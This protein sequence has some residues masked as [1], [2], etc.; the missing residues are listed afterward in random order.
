LLAT[1]RDRDNFMSSL[2]QH[3]LDLARVKQE[4]ERIVEAAKDWRVEIGPIT[5]TCER[6]L[7]NAI[8][9]ALAG[10]RGK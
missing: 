5:L 4:S 9:E 6:K 2:V 10:G 7:A 8:D 3:G 1:G